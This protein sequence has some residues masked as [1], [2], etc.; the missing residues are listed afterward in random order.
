M[1]KRKKAL[2]LAIKRFPGNAIVVSH[3]AS[4]YEGL[5]DK[6]IDVEKLSLK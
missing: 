3:E 5:A 2:K 4:F 6:V 1:M